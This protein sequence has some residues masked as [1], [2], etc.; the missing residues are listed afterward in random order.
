MRSLIVLISLTACARGSP[1]PTP[2]SLCYALEWGDSAWAPLLPRTMRLDGA[3]DTLLPANYNYLLLKPVNQ[4][5]TVG[6]THLMNAWWMQGQL[7]SLFIMLQGVDSGWRA[8]LN[9]F[10]D[11]LSGIATYSPA[12]DQQAPMLVRGRRFACPTIP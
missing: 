12:N 10:G 4:R 8:R 3:R 7:D 6:W 5:D 1:P 11:S 2:A 9:R